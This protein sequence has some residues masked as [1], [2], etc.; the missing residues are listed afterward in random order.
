MLAQRNALCASSKLATCED[1]QS[2]YEYIFTA[3]S[4]VHIH[5]CASLARGY[6]NNSNATVAAISAEVA[7]GTVDFVV[8]PGDVSYADGFMSHWDTYFRKI[9]PF[10][11]RVPYMTGPGNHELWFNFTACETVER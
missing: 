11:S 8:H 2:G 5:V 3:L 7:A 1:F 6:G 9:Q 4:L 10:A